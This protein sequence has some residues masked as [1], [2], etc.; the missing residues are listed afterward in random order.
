MANN[1]AVLHIQKGTNFGGGLGMHIDRAPGHKEHSFPHADPERLHLNQDH[2]PDEY[3]R[4][5]VPEAIALRMKTGY[6]SPRKIRANAVR[7]METILS[8]S[9]DQMIKIQEE[10]RLNEWVE[11]NK[12][13]AEEEFG[14]DNI[15]RFVLH[16]DETTPHIH[17]VTVPLTE[18]GRLSAKDVM[19]H[20]KEMRERQDNYALAMKSFGLVRGEKNSL[21]TH[22]N[23]ADYNKRVH[24]VAEKMDS[25]TVDGFLGRNKS[26]TIENLEAALR[27]ALMS[28][29]KLE[30]QKKKM[31]AKADAAFEYRT[32]VSRQAE[33]RINNQE[34]LLIKADQRISI[35]TNRLDEVTNLY[36]ELLI[37]GKA[38]SPLHGHY[39]KQFREAKQRGIE[40]TP[41]VSLNQE[42][43]L[44]KRPK[45]PKM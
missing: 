15:I 10:G 1:K 25:L 34:D 44:K 37:D 29:E 4:F 28:L 11:A 16:L 36:K 45:G 19:G 43:P 30:S 42:Q 3:K 8:G 23:A 32:E 40:S 27:T 39:M 35:L 26:K 18:D 41:K 12:K 2:T 13:F 24:I 17:C 38:I 22:D 6:T 9:H 7:F 33:V 5:T 14:A 20:K 31:Q 21:A